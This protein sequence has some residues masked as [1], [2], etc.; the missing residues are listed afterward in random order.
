MQKLQL[1]DPAMYPWQRASIGTNPWKSLFFVLVSIFVTF[2]VLSLYRSSHPEFEAATTPS[3]SS[4]LSFLSSGSAA[5]TFDPARDAS[6]TAL[7]PEQ[8][9]AA[10]PDLYQEITRARS[11]W[12][13]RNRTISK[14]DIDIS[15][16][17]DK[18]WKVL[19]HN[20]QITITDTCDGFWGKRSIFVMS[21]L[22]RA[23]LGAIAAGE[24]LPSV[25]LAITTE[26][27]AKINRPDDE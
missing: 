25:E 9:S 2:E 17:E 7:T 6:N 15:D 18:A 11:Y 14:D 26:D 13:E 5:W 23:V 21:Q 3:K 27:R 24:T 19:I 10:F 20:N 12:E 22:Y 4:K 16:R 8:C 1:Q